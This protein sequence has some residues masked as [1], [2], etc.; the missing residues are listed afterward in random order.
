MELPSLDER[1]M[2]WLGSLDCTANGRHSD[3]QP[4][5]GNEYSLRAG[6]LNDARGKGS[7][8]RERGLRTDGGRGGR[9]WSRNTISMIKSTGIER[10]MWGEG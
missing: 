9:S 7:F 6:S 3:A 5:A 8:I 2:L 10:M 1:E 4:F